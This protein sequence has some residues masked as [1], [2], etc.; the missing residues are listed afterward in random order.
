MFLKWLFPA[1]PVLGRWRSVVTPTNYVI[2]EWF[3]DSGTLD[4][5][6]TSPFVKHEVLDSPNS[7]PEPEP[8]TPSPI[9]PVMRATE[10]IKPLYAD[11]ME[12]EVKMY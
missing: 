9:P 12:I 2:K 1:P 10:R 8:R 6:Y 11:N 3:S 5:C 7:G 4:H